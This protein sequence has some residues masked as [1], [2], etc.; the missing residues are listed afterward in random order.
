MALQALGF[1]IAM[2]NMPAIRA[3]R[4]G[5]ALEV[6]IGLM[7]VPLHAPNYLMLR[8]LKSRS[9]TAVAILSQK[10]PAA[11]TR[12]LLFNFPIR[13]DFCFR[14]LSSIL[15][16]GPHK[17]HCHPCDLSAGSVGRPYRASPTTASLTRPALLLQGPRIRL[18]RVAP[19]PFLPYTPDRV[20]HSSWLP[21]H[22]L[23][24]L[25]Y[26]APC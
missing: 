19:H 6:E 7:L 11:P 17:A 16:P 24:H 18:L 10:N 21:P 13:A 4:A 15:V 12:H 14:P 25:P 8:N 2:H 9:M 22:G 5:R 3:C 20:S 26:G 1:V 23:H